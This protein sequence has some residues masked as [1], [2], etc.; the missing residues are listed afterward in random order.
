MAVKLDLA[1]CGNILGQSSD[2]NQVFINL[3]INASHACENKGLL[4]IRSVKDKDNVIIY[5]QD[6]GKGISEKH[7]LNIFDPFYTT[8]PLGEGT[9]LGLPISHA[10][11]EKHNG[12]IEVYSEVNI[13]TCFKITLPL[14]K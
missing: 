9:G 13:G 4:T 10:I 11:I 7:I 2:L 8:K 5:V 3:F 12:I 1:D 14:A 6:N